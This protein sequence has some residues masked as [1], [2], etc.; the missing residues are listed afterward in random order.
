[1]DTEDSRQKEVPI[2]NQN[3][4]VLI[5]HYPVELCSSPMCSKNLAKMP[6]W[7]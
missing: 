6:E 3:K 7:A 2:L 4:A 5:F 1:M